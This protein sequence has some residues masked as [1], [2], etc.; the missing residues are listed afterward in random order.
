M[1]T[2]KDPKWVQSAGKYI[3][4]NPYYKKDAA[5]DAKA[6]KV[7][8]QAVR[9]REAGERAA[10]FATVAATAED[11]LREGADISSLTVN[12]LKAL[13]SVRNALSGHGTSTKAVLVRRVGDIMQGYA[14]IESAETTTPSTANNPPTPTVAEAEECAVV[15][16]EDESSSDS[17]SSDS[18]SSGSDSS[19]ISDHQSDD[20][21]YTY[22]FE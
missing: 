12:K 1:D 8:N 7:E 10:T 17:D 6:A 20:V 4:C 16:S 22:T 9:E 14:I 21:E 5:V 18:E 11:E 13:L 19:D 3:N 15:E 2:S